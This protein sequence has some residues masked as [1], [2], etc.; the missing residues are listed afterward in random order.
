MRKGIPSRSK[1]DARVNAF[2]PKPEQGNAEQHY[3]R[4]QNTA[5][6]YT[7]DGGN[8]DSPFLAVGGPEGKDR[9]QQHER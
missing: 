9:G 6:Q 7:T 1:Q 3:Q 2:C 8:F 5:C 4:D